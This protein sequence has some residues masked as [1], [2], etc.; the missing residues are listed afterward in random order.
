MTPLAYFIDEYLPGTTRIVQTIAGGFGPLGMALG[1]RRLIRWG[2]RT[3]PAPSFMLFQLRGVDAIARMLSQTRAIRPTDIR[4]PS[5]PYELTLYS[6][7]PLTTLPDVRSLIA[8]TDST[9]SSVSIGRTE[10]E[11][12]FFSAQC[13]ELGINI[14]YDDER[15][16]FVAWGGLV[17]AAQAGRLDRNDSLAFVLCGARTRIGAVPEPD[18]FIDPNGQLVA[19]NNDIARRP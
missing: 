19:G 5:R 2:F 1:Y 3:K 7:A 6:M 14:S 4:F 10:N 11:A 9:V 8:N 18:H 16:A 13:K 15:C 12:P 17:D